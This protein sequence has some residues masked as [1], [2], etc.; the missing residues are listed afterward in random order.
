MRKRL[1]IFSFIYFILQ[2]HQEDFKNH[3]VSLSLKEKIKVVAI[4]EIQNQIKNL[5]EELE[6]KIK[7]L[8]LEYEGLQIPLHGKVIF[9][10]N[11]I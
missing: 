3:L 5:D 7:A 1:L 10:T 2:K 11:R 9:Y 4:N 6:Q 8:T